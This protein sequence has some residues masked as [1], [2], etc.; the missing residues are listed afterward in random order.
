M[1]LSCFY[2]LISNRILYC[3]LLFLLVLF[4]II[5][6][7]SMCVCF[8]IS[9]LRAFF[10]MFVDF[11]VWNVFFQFMLCTTLSHV[12]WCTFKT[13]KQQPKHAHNHTQ[14]LHFHM[15]FSIFVREMFLPV[16]D[17]RHHKSR[18]VVYSQN[19]KKQPTHSVTHT[20]TK[21]P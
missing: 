11:H 12:K 9:W 2:I 16:R 21:A 10:T 7:V 8:S 1:F 6:C 4:L 5:F 13:T 18:K 19:N 15:L 17:I 20:H 3:Y 14:V